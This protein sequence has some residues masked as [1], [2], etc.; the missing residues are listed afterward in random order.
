MSN[1]AYSLILIIIITIQVVILVYTIQNSNNVEQVRIDYNQFA[2]AYKSD[3]IR[4]KVSEN[5]IN[6]GEITTTMQQMFEQQNEYVNNLVTQATTMLTSDVFDLV[7]PLGPNDVKHIGRVVEFAR[8]NI[9]G[10][11]MIYIITS[12]DIGDLNDSNYEVVSESIFPFSKDDVISRG[13]YPSRA[14]WYLQQLLKMYAFT[15][16]PSLSENYMVLDADTYMLRLNQFMSKGIALLS[17]SSQRH[18]PYF[19]HM[20][21][22]HPTFTIAHKRSGICNFMMFNVRMLKDMFKLVETYHKPDGQDRLFWQI[23]LDAIDV[24]EESGASE[25]E[26]YFTYLHKFAKSTF[27]IRN[28]REKVKDKVVPAEPTSEHEYDFMSKHWH[29]Q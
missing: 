17:T 11:H 1:W 26:I 18:L 3:N 2:Q 12:Q 14:G 10:L 4:D 24:N 6:V 19:E 23:F 27:K 25:F 20:K 7:I 22:L 21:K 16:I 28:L 9:V 15:G 13:I 29:E 8:A 5:K